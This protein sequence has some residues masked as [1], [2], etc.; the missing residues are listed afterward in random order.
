MARQPTVND[1]AQ[2]NRA[3]ITARTPTQRAYIRS[4]HENPQTFVLGPAGTGKT[5]IASA[6]AA[7][8]YLRGDID[9]IVITR[10]RVEVDEEWGHLPG[11]LAQ[12]TAPWAHPITEVLE[13][14]MG[15][16]RYLQAMKDNHVEVLPLA[17]M[18]GRTLERA[19]CILDEAQNTTVRQMQM[20][21]TRIGEEARVVVNGDI[22]QKDIKADSGLAWA[23]HMLRLHSNLPAKLIEFSKSDVVRSEACAAWIQAMTEDEENHGPRLAWLNR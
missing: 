19:F 20:F 23:L 21:V 8:M 13:E 2:A 11:N 22:A 17:F 5:F 3:A 14:F 4:I 18:R 12:K 15:K 1:H 7:Q 6:I 10:P 9:K 16:A